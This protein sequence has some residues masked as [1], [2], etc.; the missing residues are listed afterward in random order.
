MSWI[1]A[2]LRQQLGWFPKFHGS[3]ARLG[4]TL[5]VSNIE[6]F[7]WVGP[8]IHRRWYQDVSG[9]HLLEVVGFQ[10]PAFWVISAWH[11]MAPFT[12]IIVFRLDQSVVPGSV[13]YD[14]SREWLIC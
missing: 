13:F 4:P 3:P 1:E 5:Q 2:K 10:E 7:T 8:K 11:G 14:D 12:I 9:G 6:E